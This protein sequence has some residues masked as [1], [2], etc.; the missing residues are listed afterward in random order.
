MKSKEN[1]VILLGILLKRTVEEDKELEE[2]LIENLDFLYT[3][4]MEGEDREV[5]RERNFV[6]ETFDL[7]ITNADYLKSKDLL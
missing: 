1:R 2:L 7:Y 3:I 4:H 5:V 6:E